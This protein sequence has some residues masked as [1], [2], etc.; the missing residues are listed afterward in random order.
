MAQQDITSPILFGGGYVKRFD[1]SLGLNSSFSSVNIDIVVDDQGQAGAPQTFLENEL[2]PGNIS[3]FTAGQ[4]NFVG[5]VQSW[6]ES[7]A[8]NGQTYKVRLVDP[9]VMF[10]DV[11]VMT[12]GNL[13]RLP[14]NTLLG[15]GSGI[16]NVINAY[17]YYSNDASAQRNDNGMAWNKIKQALEATGFITVYDKRFALNF[18]SGFAG[19]DY[20]R[21][22]ADE[23]SLD[24][25][26]QSVS[27]SLGLDY[28]VEI[29]R[30]YNS[31]SGYNYININ[32][33][34]REIAATGISINQL[35]TAKRSSGILKSYVRGKEL[36]S[37]PTDV[38]VVGENR[39]FIHTVQNTYPSYGR[40]VDGI[41]LTAA[42]NSTT[43]GA[44]FEPLDDPN[45]HNGWVI[46]ENI[47]NDRLD[48]YNNIPLIDPVGQTTY[49]QAGGYPLYVVQDVATRSIPGY[50]PTE[51]VMRAAL[52]SRESWEAVLFYEQ[53][54]VA[55]AIG[56]NALP[57]REAN[58]L[59]A[60]VGFAPDSAGGIKTT[61]FR[62]GS[63]LLREPDE[64]IIIQAVYEATQR[65]ADQ[66]YGKQFLI[67]LPAGEIFVNGS[68]SG[69]G[70]S[71]RHGYRISDSAWYEN[72][73]TA[74]RHSSNQNFRDDLGLIKAHATLTNARDNLVPNIVI[75]NPNGELIGTTGFL[76]YDLS[77]YDINKYLIDGTD[78]HFSVRIEQDSTNKSRA[79][80]SLDQPVE[81]AGFGTLDLTG[82]VPE[83]HGTGYIVPTGFVSSGYYVAAT[84]G[85][86]VD[87]WEFWR[88][89][90]L[91]DLQ[92]VELGKYYQFNTQ[93]GLGKQRV[94][95][96]NLVQVP[97]EN[98]LQQYGPFIAQND[99]HGGTQL[100]RD[101]SLAPWTF[102][103]TATL[104][105]AGADVAS[106]ALMNRTVIDTAQLVCAGLP[107][108]NMGEL[109]G[110]NA[111]I[112]SLNMNMGVEGLTT[113]YGLQTFISPF[114]RISQALNSKL[115]KNTILTNKIQKD[116][117]VLNK[118][119][120]NIQSQNSYYTLNNDRDG[121]NELLRPYQQPSL[122]EWM[123]NNTPYGG[124]TA[125]A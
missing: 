110:E 109:L 112:T 101:N 32:A 22:N 43:F 4:F 115:S 10:G 56:I 89:F 57:F 13:I 29:D 54:T 81:Y 66:F 47:V 37:G 15:V 36:R 17:S 68:A 44:S 77:E 114:V 99:R 59:I 113:S 5:I 61:V 6:E 98:E 3:G 74:L 70:L 35:I 67:E 46:L 116:V 82:R 84:S 76:R 85:V 79:I 106:G 9:R 72:A 80:M 92:I 27:A 49:I 8:E 48:Y 121:Y 11:Y 23:I 45:R 125:F 20:L 53:P 118:R 60:Q 73:S 123:R 78:I 91:T 86:P 7:Y 25:L 103:S 51:N 19:P 75:H 62:M 107:E 97:L 16:P 120:D 34:S 41:L 88:I 50:R 83:Y 63:E 71:F 1:A 42:E 2:T 58:D 105:A 69:A 122:Q 87:Y 104:N 40:T 14:N 52:F 111:N 108:H 96:F 95:Y 100:I 21:I 102:G 31:S 64:E 18:S 94:T 33:I 28:Y 55:A 119:L 39:R 12:N 24:S 117:N 93:L 124:G 30:N 38:L 90:G 26:L 65:V